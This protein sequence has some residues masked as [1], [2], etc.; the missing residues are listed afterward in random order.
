MWFPKAGFRKREGENHPS[1]GPK[2]PLQITP[3]LFAIH[4]YK[5]VQHRAEQR[6][7]VVPSIYTQVF[8][9]LPY[10]PP[11]KYVHIDSWLGNSLSRSPRVDSGMRQDFKRTCSEQKEQERS[12][13]LPRVSAE[14]QKKIRQCSII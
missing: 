4:P 5:A 12:F 9:H 10:I 14:T 3:K 2:I 13:T 11:S 7:C 6:F 8:A 1:L